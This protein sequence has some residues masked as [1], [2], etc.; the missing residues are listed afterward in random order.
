MFVFGS[1]LYRVEQAVRVSF[2]IDLCIFLYSLYL[3][4]STY[5]VT[6]Q[7]SDLLD[8]SIM[9]RL[10]SIS[11][12]PSPSMECSSIA[13]SSPALKPGPHLGRKHKHKHRHL[14]ASED[15]HHISI[16]INISLSIK[17]LRSS[18]AYAYAYVAIVSSE[19]MLV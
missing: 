12:T 17:T 11:T 16:S 19:D 3:V 13:E 4:K 2:V 14:C 1:Y 7:A 6:H 9:Q 8:F 5:I 15:G 18:Y 10:G